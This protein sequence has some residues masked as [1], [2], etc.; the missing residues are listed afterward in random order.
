MVILISD[1]TNVP[2]T[3]CQITKLNF[4]TRGL[5]MYEKCMY[6]LSKQ[7]FLDKNKLDDIYSNL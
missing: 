2:R 7:D 4:G 3:F 5:D 1:P 6:D